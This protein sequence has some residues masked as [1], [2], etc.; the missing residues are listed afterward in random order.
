MGLG[1]IL[2]IGVN[3]G[4]LHLMEESHKHAVAQLRVKLLLLLTLLLPK[5]GKTS[6]RK[7]VIYE[8]KSQ[9][10]AARSQPG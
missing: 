1:E 9:K 3:Y 2:V 6:K 10:V 5:E 4:V 7:W 8:A